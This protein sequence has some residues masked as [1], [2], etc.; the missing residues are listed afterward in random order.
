MHAADSRVEPEHALGMDFAV[1]LRI[2]MRSA[3]P[4]RLAKYAAT[5]QYNGLIWVFSI[6]D[7]DPSPLRPLEQYGFNVESVPGISTAPSAPRSVLRPPAMPPRASG[8]SRQPPLPD[9]AAP[10]F[11]FTPDE[12][13][14]VNDLATVNVTPRPGFSS[15]DMVSEGWLICGQVA[16]GNSPAAIA[17]QLF[18]KSTGMGPGGINRSQADSIVKFSLKDLCP[19]GSE[20]MRGPRPVV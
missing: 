10:G 14:F 3:L 1:R 15:Y 20:K 11:L 6:S 18:K 2:K 4:A 19:S 9:A 12:T 5:A 16:S 17:D 7:N 13:K 8:P